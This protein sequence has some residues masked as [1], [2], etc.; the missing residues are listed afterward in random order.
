MGGG[1]YRILGN[2]PPTPQAASSARAL[3]DSGLEGPFYP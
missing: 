3:A 2:P 1:V